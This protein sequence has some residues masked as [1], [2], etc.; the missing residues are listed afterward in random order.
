MNLGPLEDAIGDR[1]KADTG[2]GGLWEQSGGEPVLV[3][4]ISNQWRD[5]DGSLSKPVVVFRVE[6]ADRFDSQDHDGLSV[7]LTVHVLAPASLGTAAARKALDR[8]YG[9][10]ATNSG[11]PAVG[12]HRWEP[13]DISV[14]HA[15]M[16]TVTMG[17]SILRR[18]AHATNH[19]ADFYEWIET[20][21]TEV[22][23]AFQ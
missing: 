18:I 17:V 23:I 12:L 19:D 8:I 6:S 5:P 4:E 3:G 9:N 13:E 10:A 7:R 16:G 14:I 11:T 2:T 15:A 22:A 1:L 20:Y 21:E